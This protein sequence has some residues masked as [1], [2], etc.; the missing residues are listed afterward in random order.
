LSDKVLQVKIYEDEGFVCLP[1]ATK[2][3]DEGCG[4][5]E[6]DMTFVSTYNPIS[7]RRGME[8]L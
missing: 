5:L 4:Q 2:I 7:D 3:V 8:S 1:S 6:M